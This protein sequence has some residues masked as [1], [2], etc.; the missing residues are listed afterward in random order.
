MIK[1]HEKFPNWNLLDRL[2]FD[3]MHNYYKNQ[4]FKTRLV[5]G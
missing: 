2:W 1:L 4:E 5:N 3:N